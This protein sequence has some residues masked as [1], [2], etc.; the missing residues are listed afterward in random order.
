MYVRTHTTTPWAMA[1]VWLGR[2]L[3]TLGIINGGLGLRYAADTK[4]G[5]IAYGVIAGV[6]WVAWVGVVVW[7]AFF[8][9]KD[10]RVVENGVRGKEEEGEEGVRV[11]E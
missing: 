9:V 2:V 7:D 5:E 11:S 4:K 6:V 3:I 10:K 1:H 8:R